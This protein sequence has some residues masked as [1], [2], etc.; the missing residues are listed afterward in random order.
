MPLRMRNE[1]RM[2][3]TAGQAIFEQLAQERRGALSDWRALVLLRRATLTTP[4]HLRRW[5]TLPTSPEEMHPLLSQMAQRSELAPLRTL[6]HV[7]RVTVPYAQHGLLGEDEVLMEAHPYA[8][9][10]HH[11]ALVYHN[12]TDD[13]PHEMIVIVPAARAGDLLPL[14]TTP[15]DWESVRLPPGQTPSR[16]LDVRMHWV[17]V[18]PKRLFGF[19]EYRRQGYPVRVTTPE[20]TLADALLDPE[21]CGGWE[22]VLR[23]WARARDTLNLNSLVHVVEQFDIAVLRQRVGFLLDEL[24]IP[25]PIVEGWRAGARR[26]GSSRLLGS[27]PY[28]PTYSERWNLSL[29]ASLAAL[30]E[31]MT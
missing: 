7:Y 15:D 8:T 6:H 11:S 19:Q 4:P 10:S 25:S 24:G 21:L 13:L 9:L 22:T 31:S 3:K 5:T 1:V 18:T 17:R 23:A 26:G 12:L 27:A 16:I 28:A 14:G 2:K 30:T 20:R 29:N